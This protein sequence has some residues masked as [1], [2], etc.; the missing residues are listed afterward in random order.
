MK[1]IRSQ[2]L[3]SGKASI[4][5]AHE[6]AG[7]V[8]LADL[9]SIKCVKLSKHLSKIMRQTKLNSVVD[10]VEGMPIDCHRKAR[11]RSDSH[12]GKV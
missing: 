3:C 7:E 8:L 1:V 9:N 2:H 6:G 11:E 12:K 4:V 10:I 5:K